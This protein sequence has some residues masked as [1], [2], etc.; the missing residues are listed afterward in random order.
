MEKIV[1]KVQQPVRI[2]SDCVPRR[3]T[4]FPRIFGCG[5]A[6]A[7]G[8]GVRYW[9]GGRTEGG[10]LLCVGERETASQS[11]TVKCV[12]GGALLNSKMG[13]TVDRTVALK[14]IT[15]DSVRSSLVLFEMRLVG[16]VRLIV[17]ILMHVGSIATPS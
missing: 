13:L 3:S 5:V 4:E 1:G 10:S 9:R 2:N 14:C 7:S 17:P 12:A 16:Y 8:R 15:L 6:A 11:V